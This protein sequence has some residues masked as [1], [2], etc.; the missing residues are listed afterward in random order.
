MGTDTFIGPPIPEEGGYGSEGEMD[1][2]KIPLSNEV[3]LK[4]HSK[5]VSALAI[6][7]SGSRVLTGSYDYMVKMYDFQGM[8]AKLASFREFEPSEGH[9]VR[10]LS[11]SP[12]GDLFLTVT[13]SAQAKVQFVFDTLAMFFDVKFLNRV[14]IYDRDGFALGE[15]EKGDMYLRDLRHTKGHIC[16]LTS[17]E[18]HP[19]ERSTI[20][21][22][23][24]DG[25]VR[26]WDIEDFKK[27]K[28]LVKPK[29]SRPGRISVTSCTWGP[30]GSTIAAGLADGSVQIWQTKGLGHGSLPSQY[31]K[32][33]HES[34]E[35]VTAV[36]F[37]E[38]GKTL[39]SRSTDGTLKIW[40]L[41]K[42]KSPLLALDSLPCCYPS[43]GLAWGPDQKLLLT[44]TS[45]EK[46]GGKTGGEHG[47]GGGQVVFVDREKLEVVR[48]VG[49]GSSA[50]VRVAWHSKINQV[51]FSIPITS[52]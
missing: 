18:W 34:G 33:A 43:T 1:D 39:S 38:D 3:V 12:S 48:K 2:Y 40:D 15:F 8:N 19:E 4:G 52:L 50:V 37:S 49:V 42:F 21:T 45:T 25:S 35:D 17:G 24:E 28:Q 10:A 41:R 32:D 23:S 11:F 36:L 27:H 44:G 5:V 9:Q 31:L 30:G 14:Q 6:D 7:P 20:M 47:D 22:A 29:L 16:G 13:G 26:L 46:K 51:S